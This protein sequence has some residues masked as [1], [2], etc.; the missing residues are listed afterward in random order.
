[1]QLPILH[2][3]GIELGI[4]KTEPPILDALLIRPTAVTLLLNVWPNGLVKLS[5]CYCYLYVS[6]W[7]NAA[8]LIGYSSA[9]HIWLNVL[10]LSWIEEGMPFA[11]LK[12]YDT[13]MLGH[14]L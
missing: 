10:S 1:M 9:M 12:E 3:F 2:L 4:C 14:Y 11:S 6:C 8:V 13:V 5:G 7:H